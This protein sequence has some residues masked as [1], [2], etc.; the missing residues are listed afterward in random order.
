MKYFKVFRNHENYEENIGSD[1]F[2]RPNISYCTNENEIHFYKNFTKVKFNGV[3]AKI[4]QKNTYLEIGEP[5]TIQIEVEPDY[6]V[7]T[8]SIYMNGKNY[9]NQTWNQEQEKFVISKV[10][11]NIIINVVAEKF[12]LTKAY[13]S[14]VTIMQ[15]TRN[16]IHGYINLSEED[17][18]NNNVIYNGLELL[19][20]KQEGFN[21]NNWQLN[22]EIP[23]YNAGQLVYNQSLPG[24]D[25]M[26]PWSSVAG[27]QGLPIGNKK[28]FTFDISTNK[29]IGKYLQT[30]SAKFKRD[31]WRNINIKSIINVIPYERLIFNEIDTKLSTIDPNFYFRDITINKII[32]ANEWTPICLPFDIST[33][34]DFEAIFGSDVEVVEFMDFSWG[35]NSLDPSQNV[36][37]ND[38]SED[39]IINYETYQNNS[40]PYYAKLEPYFMVKCNNDITELELNDFIVNNLDFNEDESYYEYDNGRMGTRRIVYGGIYGSF[41]KH[42]IKENDIILDGKTFKLSDG[43]LPVKAFNTYIWIDK[44]NNNF[45][46]DI[47]LSIDNVIIDGYSKN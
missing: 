43:K 33:R 29:E 7:K 15:N 35:S 21:F 12:K 5:A 3:N 47:K 10:E 45:S 17:I 28:L 41:H 8:V 36:A 40:V 11:D 6:Y 38:P 13:F 18:K 4:N 19:F 46:G 2:K 44:L 25:Y 39:V 31:S 20:E 24:Y 27:Y 14:N 37:I 23:G 30:N 9:T 42:N 26:L 16:L 32:N 22:T 1:N 34:Q